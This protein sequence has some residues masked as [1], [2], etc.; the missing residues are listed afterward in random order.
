MRLPT[1]A[2]IL[3]CVEP[4][5]QS[6]LMQPS[7]VQHNCNYWQISHIIYK[8]PKIERFFD[9][10]L[11]KKII[12]FMS[13]CSPN[14]TC[15]IQSGWESWLNV[16]PCTLIFVLFLS[17]NKFGIWIFFTFLLNQIVRERRNLQTN[18]NEMKFF[19]VFRKIP[20]LFL[21][22]TNYGRKKVWIQNER[23]MRIRTCSI[24]EIA[25]SD[26]RPRSLR[27]LVKS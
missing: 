15:M 27:A 18:K 9:D 20:I 1:T 8:W 12:K 21:R 25:T 23:K 22:K 11:R 3:C 26:S 17:P 4:L 19:F 24:L 13:R 14:I 6:L 2:P 7:I 16:M 10:F 5:I